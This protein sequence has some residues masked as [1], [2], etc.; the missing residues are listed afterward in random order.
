MRWQE[1]IPSFLRE[2]IR[3]FSPSGQEEEVADLILEKMEEL[4]FDEVTRDRMGNVV[5]KISGGEGAPIIFDGH[6]D[7]AEVGDLNNW[8]V[9]PFSGVSLDGRIYGRGSVDMKG[10]LASMIYG[11][12]SAE[13]SVDLYVVCVVH[14]ET[15]EGVALREVLKGMERRPRAVVLGEPTDLNLSVGQRGR[16]VLKVVTRGKTAH[17]SMPELGR[18]AIYRMIPILRKIEVENRRLPTHPLLG[19]GT[20]AVTDIRAMP[21]GP[22]I[23]DRCEITVDRR[24]IIGEDREG[25]LKEVRGLAPEAEVEVVKEELLCYTGYRMEV[26]SYFPPWLLAGDHPLV[27]CSLGA[28]KGA[29]GSEPEV[30]VW[31][32]STDGVAS[33]GVLGIPTIGFGP[34]DPSMAHQPDEWVGEK[35]VILAARGYKALAESLSEV[36]DPL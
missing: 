4:G 33:A 34:G 24:M 11:C 6:M 8:H 27:R 31:R 22:I 26:E 32:F 13:P 20:M 16:C 23:P 12:A 9:D 15:Y 14:E 28:L 30:T 25:I 29:L 1:E 18:N 3:N 19:K 36:G 17:A 2:L 10:G 5:G 35:E 21:G 7:V